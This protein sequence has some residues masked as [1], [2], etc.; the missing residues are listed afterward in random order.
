MFI[1][2]NHFCCVL[3]KLLKD[4]FLLTQLVN[5]MQTYAGDKPPP[6]M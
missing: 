4:F 6:K 3:I 1:L 5:N 2:V